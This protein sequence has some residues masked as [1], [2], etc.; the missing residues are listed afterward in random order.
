MSIKK[1]LPDNVLVL[2]VNACGFSGL[3]LL[4]FVGVD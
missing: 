4:R 3:G 2:F 1:G